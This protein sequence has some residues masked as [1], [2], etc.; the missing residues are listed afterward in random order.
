MWR[1]ELDDGLA[2]SSPHVTRAA[3]CVRAHLDDRRKVNSFVVE[4]PCR[5]QAA[6]HVA[7]NSVCS[8]WKQ[9]YVEH[10]LND[11]VIRFE[12][13]VKYTSRHYL[14]IYEDKVLHQ[15]FFVML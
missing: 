8:T 1:E 14:F 7:P 4:G 2:G 3:V 15:T 13:K 11:V 12:L 9:L 5:Q 10:P 6:H